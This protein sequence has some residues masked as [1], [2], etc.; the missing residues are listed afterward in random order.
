MRSPGMGWGGW[1]AR[2]D[3]EIRDVKFRDV[4]LRDVKLRDVKLRD[5]PPKTGAASARGNSC[6]WGSQ[7]GLSSS[8]GRHWE[9]S[10]GCK[11]I[12]SPSN[13]PHSDTCK[14]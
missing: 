8:R 7:K 1:L 3:V 6:C 4:K 13:K 10:Q 12:V 5:A 11:S 14:T 2:G 9:Q